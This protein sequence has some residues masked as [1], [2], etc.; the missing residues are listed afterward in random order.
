MGMVGVLAWSRGMVGVRDLYV[1][2]SAAMGALM[3]AVLAVMK[4]SL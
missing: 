2:T 3:A 4:S 1:T